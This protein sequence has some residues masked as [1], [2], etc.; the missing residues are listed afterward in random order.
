MKISLN[1]LKDFV[2]LPDDLP[3]SKI[4][5]DLTMTTVEV[6]GAEAMTDKFKNIIVGR[7]VD[8][9]PHPNADKL[10]ICMTDVGDGE[11]KQIVCGGCNLEPGM[12]V[13]VSAPGAMVRWHGE[14]EPVEVKIAKLRGVESWGMICASTEIGLFD[15]F[16]FTEPATVVDLS[17]FDA[18]PGT[19]V[20]VALGIDDVIFEIDNK[21]LTNRPDLWGHYGIARELSAIYDL[22]LAP[23]PTFDMPASDGGLRVTIDDPSRCARYFGAV[24]EDVSVKPS[25][26]DIQTRI[27]LVGMRPINALVDVTNYVMLATGQPTH[28]FDRDNIKGGITVRRASSGESLAL[29]NG[30]AASIGPD[31]LVIADDVE[32]VALAGIMGGSKDSVLPTTNAL[33]LEIANF[34]ALGT[35]KTAQKNDLRTEASMRYEKGLDPQR[36]AQAAGYAMEIFRREFPNMRVAG[37]VDVYPSPLAPKEI[38]V[39]LD[40]LARRMGRRLSDG[41]L[42]A[43]LERLGFAVSISGDSMHVTAPSWRSTGDISLPD[44]IMEETARLIGYENFE[45]A[46]ITTTFTAA[47]NQRETSM[48]RRMREYLSFRCGMNEIF[49]YPWVRTDLIEA[50]GADRSEMLEISTPPSP[51]ERFVRSSLVPNILGAVADNARYFDEFSLYELTQVFSK[52][53]FSAPYDERERLPRQRRHLAGAFVG[54]SGAD[55]LMRLWREAKGALEEMP[56]F[57]HAEPLSFAQSSRPA[58]ADETVWLNVTTADGGVIGTLAL[59]AKKCALACGIKNHSVVAF[60][61]DVDCMVSL[62]SRTNTFVHLPEFPRVDYDISMLFDESVKWEQIAALAYTK[63]DAKDPNA[64]VKSV[65]FV[66]D[67]RG[68]QIPAG[69]KSITLRLVIGS[70]KKTLSGDEIEKAAAVVTKRLTKQLGGEL[71][72]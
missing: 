41:E 69:K 47:I 8:V 62:V 21:S 14:G 34:D 3:I 55:S 18:E 70:D 54:D 26:F 68:K 23:L 72:G 13:A 52:A 49:T 7:I 37:A 59:V 50:T 10:R 17:A 19:N 48:P 9:Q 66:G 63:N 6:E 1:W 22:P 25:S 40:W 30:K 57:I 20:A 32:P 4:M 46:P 67:Y 35:R 51:E 5:Y 24:I 11:T 12:K 60:E 58:W 65:A 42:R 29:L 2:K 27:W 56:R 53:E 61:L 71:R 45:A 43:T 38:E 31:D 33:I 36:V 39:S 15:L 64:L 16:P 28:A 44:D